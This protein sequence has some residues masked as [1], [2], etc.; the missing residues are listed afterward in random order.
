MRLTFIV[1]PSFHG[2]TLL[3]LLLNNHSRI[4]ALG[5]ANPSRAYDQTCACGKE[6]SQCEYWQGVLRRLHSDR[7][8][9]RRLMLPILPWPLESYRI[10]GRALPISRIEPINRGVGRAAAAILDATLPL[11]WRRGTRRLND[12]LQLYSTYYEYVL[13]L[14]RTEMIVDGSKSGRKVA[15]FARQLPPGDVKVIHLV[16][17][18][19][20]FAASWRHN[21]EG[22]DVGA[23]AWLWRDIHG[24]YEALQDVLPYC[25]VRYEDLASDTQSELERIL[26]FIE[27]EP[28]NVIA[29]PQHP[30]KHHLMGNR[31]LFGFDG[32]VK[33]D[34][35]WRERLTD[36]E[37]RLVLGRA[38]ERAR[39]LG[40]A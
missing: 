28:Q 17:D 33:L 1:C 14:H 32:T 24:R 30:G 29:P 16:R 40:Y 11:L 8:E 39:K 4:S 31:M 22:E 3:H 13:G 21:G 6:V 12:Y 7:F 38:G 25:R 20:G 26:T 37:Q 2:S 19:R 9:H 27:M 10:E 15:L 35:V 5:D 36:E 23:A 34:E 18:P